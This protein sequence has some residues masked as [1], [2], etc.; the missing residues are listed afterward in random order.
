MAFNF[1]SANHPVTRYGA[2]AAAALLAVAANQAASQPFAAHYP[3]MF[4]IAGVLFGAWFG[5]LGPGLLATAITGSSAI[6]APNFESLAGIPHENAF[7]LRLVVYLIESM[8]ISLFCGNVRQREA[9]MS[10]VLAHREKPAGSL[11]ERARLTRLEAEIGHLITQS[12]TIEKVLQGCVHSLV[13]H[14]DAAFA[15]IWTYN[16]TEQMLELQVSAGLYTHID[17][18]HGRVPLGQ[19][20]IGLIASERKPHLTNQVMGDPR[21]NNQEWARQEK[22]V[23]FAGYPLLVGERLYG[24]L[25]MFAKHR[26]SEA[27]LSCA[28]PRRARDRPQP[29][30]PGSGAERVVAARRAS[31]ARNGRGRQSGQGRIHCHRLAR[32]AHAAQ[33]HPGL[34]ALLETGDLTTRGNRGSGHT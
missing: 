7:Y 17:G 3:F 9:R 4:L 6:F 28:G 5:G 25:A 29:A 23:A 27:S 32:V 24:V 16:E 2:A 31:G 1:P 26:L 8:L 34:G 30:T 10:P 22:M 14:V 12:D 21:V 15:R 18:P 11:E 33:R 13:R 19:F 20:K